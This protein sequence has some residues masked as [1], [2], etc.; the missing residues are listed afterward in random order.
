MDDN[1]IITQC[2][3]CLTQFRVTPG[4]LKL[5]NGQVRCGACLHVFN[6][7]QNSLSPPKPKTVSPTIN[8]H[9]GKAPENSQPPTK[10]TSLKKPVVTSPKEEVSTTKIT[11]TKPDFSDLNIHAEPVLL[12]APELAVKKFPAGWFTAC[13]LAGFLLGFQYLWFNKTDIYWKYPQTRAF[14]D[15]LCLQMQCS[16]LPQLSLALIENQKLL[17]TPHPEYEGAIE[18]TLVLINKA[19]ST[20]PF[21]ALSLEFR[22]LK[23]RLVAHKVIEPSN[24][25]DLQHADPLAMPPQQPIQITLE[26][27]S[28]GTRAVNYQL[29]LIA[30]SQ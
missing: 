6:A 30:P 18:M 13:L 29:D 7:S 24:Y 3:G 16:I 11:S 17:I 20:Q 15:Q 14:L 9:P 21:P 1:S 12:D 26:M 28:P 27:L 22:D 8:D 23:G 19:D 2:P 25:L 10:P 5:A 4:Q